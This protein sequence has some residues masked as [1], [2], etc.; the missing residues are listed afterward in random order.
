M[1]KNM[2]KH[3][4]NFI[5]VIKIAIFNYIWF[6]LTIEIVRAQRDLICNLPITDNYRLKREDA[7][8]A[9]KLRDACSKS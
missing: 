2:M 7:L 8:F 6:R 1:R 5:A 3:E 4:V 9:Q